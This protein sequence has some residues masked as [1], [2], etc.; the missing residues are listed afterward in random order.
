MKNMP[1]LT[2]SATTPPKQTNKMLGIPKANQEIV[3]RVFR[4]ILEL[5]EQSFIDLL[6]EHRV[7]Y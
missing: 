1:V 2:S 6:K 5:W 4:V 3:G 7:F